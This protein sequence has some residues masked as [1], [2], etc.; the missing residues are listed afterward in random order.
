MALSFD[1]AATIR[2]FA[3]FGL[4]FNMFLNKHSDFLELVFLTGVDV[5]ELHHSLVS[6]TNDGTL[7]YSR[8]E[9]DNIVISYS[10]LCS[11]FPPQL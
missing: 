3:V 9:D 8:Y 10:T 2:R 5:R 1:F 7:K 4:T 6:D 11:L